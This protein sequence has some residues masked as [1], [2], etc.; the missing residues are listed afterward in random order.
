MHGESSESNDDQKTPSEKSSTVV[1]MT[2]ADTTWRMFVPSIGFT[3]L[4][5][6]LDA[7]YGT[8]PWLMFSGIVVGFLVATLAVKLQYDKLIKL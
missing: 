6:W 4:G 3:F 7:K 2:I 1:L 5:I 8:L